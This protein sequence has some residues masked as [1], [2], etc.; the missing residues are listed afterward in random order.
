VRTEAP[1]PAAMAIDPVCGMRVDT[2]A[3]KPTHAHDGVIYHFC[4]NGCRT[5]FA[6]DPPRYLD[7]GRKAEPAARPQPTGTKYT[8]PMDPEIV[9]IGPGTC[10]KCGMALEPMGVPSS[11]AGPDPEYVDFL[12]RF[13]VGLVLTL[14]LV[15]LA[16]GEHLGLPVARWLGAR[17]ALWVQLLLAAPVVLWCGRPFFERALASLRNRS[18]NMWTLIGL[19]VGAAFLFSV[20]ATV[21][22]G[23][24]PAAL[25]T[26]GGTVGV[27][28]EAAAVIIVLV[29]AGQLLELTARARTADAIRGL[30]RLAPKTARRLGHD[31]AETDVPLEEVVAGDKLRVRPGEAVPVDGIIIDGASSIDESLLTGEPMPVEKSAGARVTGATLNST[32]SFVM[33]ARKVGADTV[34]ARIVATVAEAQRSRAPVQALVDRVA[35][36]F[37]PAVALVAL[38]AFLAWLALGP[39]PQLAYA[40]V[41][42]VSVLIIAC[43]CALGLAT[44]MSIM[45]ATG[46]G[47]REGVLVREAAALEALAQVDTLVIDKTGTLTEGRPR[48]TDV[49]VLPGFDQKMQLRLAAGLEKGS[50]HPVAAAIVAAAKEKRIAVVGA[51]S[52]T[53]VPGEG[54]HGRVAGQDVAVGNARLMERLG[55]AAGPAILIVEELA[56]EGKTAVLV[57]LNGRAAGVLAFADPIKAS[58]ADAVA[59]L[60]A[61]GTRVIMATGDRRETAEAVARRLGIAEVHAGMAPEAKARLVGELTAAG[62]N[63]AF[64]GDGINDAPALAMARAGIAMGSGSDIAI[65]GAGIVLP[66]GD[67]GG[68]VRAMRLAAATRANIRQN[69]AFAF[70]YNALGVPVAAGLLYPWTG[71]MLSPII[72][73]VAMSLSSLSVIANALRLRLTPLR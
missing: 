12:Q 47:A 44:P 17:G 63:V 14:P 71:M 70:G 16:M 27:Y 39:T 8:C 68:I 43:P 37:V 72:A 29:L 15:V 35:R 48:L 31:G 20:A 54:A 46:R 57:A 58:A 61:R 53:A 40:L 25:G 5:R 73:A 13:K 19:G 56:R 33:E 42:A 50:E 41:A 6:A 59:A 52:F 36:W 30:L 1:E 60:A 34:L 51:E 38:A 9:Q 23:W 22:P 45:V 10:P 18:P 66:K 55:I 69:L 67:L 21:A 32:G 3:G 64:A 2:G 62:R 26:H 4:C 28:Y 65:E 7:A 11:E 49:R 24:F